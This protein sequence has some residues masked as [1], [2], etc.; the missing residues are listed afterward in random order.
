MGKD[1]RH[2]SIFE[3]NDEH[4]VY[5]MI[6]QD[7]PRGAI[8]VKRFVITGITRDK[9]YDLTKGT[10]GSRILYLG[11]SGQNIA[12]NVTVTLKPRPKLKNL[13]LVVKFNEVLV[14]NRS[15]IGNVLTKFP[16]AKLRPSEMVV[17]SESKTP[18]APGGKSQIKL[19]L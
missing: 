18:P 1:I 3:K 13:N 5:N 9:A 2:I 15:A 8:M 16:V 4:T 17:E 11:I 7:G 10:E 6:Y 12:P 19:E 14:K